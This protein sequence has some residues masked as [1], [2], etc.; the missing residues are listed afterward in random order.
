[1]YPA[2]L[3]TDD[4]QE[5]RATLRRVLEPQGFRTLEAADGVEAVEIVRREPVHLV[6]IDMHMPRLTGLEAIRRF[7][8]IKA[9]LPCILLS[10]EAD[11][12]I[13]RQARQLQAFGVLRKP[14][15]RR[16][17][18]VT[19]TQALRTV[20]NWSAPGAGSGMEANPAAPP[21]VP[22]RASGGGRPQS[23][24]G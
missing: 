17:I 13:E 18:T 8:E 4:D 9:L 2:I 6:L 20:Y 12:E 15:T 7:R 11:E 19:V 16:V 24:A 10:A 14:V 21:P 23:Q 5:F 3:I 22:P 1:M